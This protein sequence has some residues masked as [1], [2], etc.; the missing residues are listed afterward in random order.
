M[1]SSF[2]LWSILG[3][4]LPF[5]RSE[6]RIV[7]ISVSLSD[8]AIYLV[9][10]LSFMQFPL[11][12]SPDLREKDRLVSGHGEQR[13]SRPPGGNRSK[14]KTPREGESVSSV[15]DSVSG[16]SALHVTCLRQRSPLYSSRSSSMHQRQRIENWSSSLHVDPIETS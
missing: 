1:V 6:G 3:W 14:R 15:D 16:S 2:S 5:L 8:K 9:P 10:S 7:Q 12:R 11:H 13:S 4:G